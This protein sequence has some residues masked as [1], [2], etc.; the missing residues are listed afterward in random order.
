MQCVDAEHLREAIVYTHLNP[1]A[2]G[3]CERSEDY[4]WSSQRAY[5]GGE[6]HLSMPR[7]AVEL[8]LFAASDSR[9]ERAAAARL[10]ALRELAGDLSRDSGR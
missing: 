3:L 4:R 7:L 5:S 1:V 10:P 8:E 6:L 2:A 9:N